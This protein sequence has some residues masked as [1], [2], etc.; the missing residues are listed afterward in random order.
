[1]RKMRLIASN[2]EKFM[3]RRNVPHMEKKCQNCDGRNRWAK[4]SRTQ[5]NKQKNMAAR[6]VNAIE[7]NSENS[8]TIY[9]RELKS[10]NELDTKETN[11]VL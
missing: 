6:R 4:M 8:G 10:V 3:G 2:V 9:T 5:R 1:M 7:E 11:C